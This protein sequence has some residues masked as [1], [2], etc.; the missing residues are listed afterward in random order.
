VSLIDFGTTV[1]RP[2]DRF[3]SQEAAFSHLV[4]TSGS[5]H[6][7][8]IR[9]G[10]NGVLG[11]HVAPSAQLFC[12]VVGEGEV[13]GADAIPVQIQA[14]QAALWEIGESHETTTRT[15][16]TAIILEVEAVHP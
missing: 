12:V 7:G 3:E 8:C 15:G 16:L 9:L 13:S 1:A 4:D 10:N 14:G 5:G 11:R 6:V 2:V